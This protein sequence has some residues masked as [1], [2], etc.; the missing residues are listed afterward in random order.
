MR[1][2]VLSDLHIGPNGAWDFMDRHEQLQRAL[3]EQARAHGP[4]LHL[5]LNGDSFDFLTFADPLDPSTAVR[6]AEELVCGVPGKALLAGMRAVLTAGGQVTVRLGNH[7]LELGFPEVQEVLRGRLGHAERLAFD[8][9]EVMSVELGGQRLAI[10]HGEHDDDWN[11]FPR[12]RLGSAD[13]AVYPPG[14]ELVHGALNPAKLLGYR[15]ADLLKP[16]HAAAAAA[17]VVVDPLLMTRLRG[18]RVASL[19]WRLFWRGEGELYRLMGVAGPGT[20]PSLMELDDQD[21]TAWEQA[22]APLQR[23]HTDGAAPSGTRDLPLARRLLRALFLGRS[24]RVRIGKQGQAFF[25]LEP[26]LSEWDLARG[27]EARSG[28]RLVLLGHSHAATF[29]RFDGLTVLNTGTW[30]PLIQPPPEDA[31]D[32]EWDAFLEELL[33]DPTLSGPAQARVLRRL[34]GAVVEAQDGAVAVQLLQWPEQGGPP[35]VL[36]QA[37]LGAPPAASRGLR[38]LIAS[39]AAPPAPSAAWH[40]AHRCDALEAE[41]AR[42]ARLDPTRS[43]DLL[44]PRDHLLLLSDVARSRLDRARER[45]DPQALA[46]AEATWQLYRQADSSRRDRH[47]GRALQWADAVAFD[48][49]HAVFDRA[50]QAGFRPRGRAPVP[51]CVVE[52]GT[53]PA[54]WPRGTTVPSPGMARELALELPFP[55]ILLPPDHLAMPGWLAVVLHEVGHDLDHDLGLRAL[56]WQAWKPLL[57]DN[58]RAGA[59]ERWLPELLA[60]LIGRRLGGPGFADALI[61]LAGGLD[62]AAPWSDRL[63]VH[64]PV[65]LRAWMVGLVDQ[66]INQEAE[67]Y[68]QDWPELQVALWAVRLG[69]ASLETLAPVEEPAGWRG[70][71]GRVQREAAQVAE[72]DR[73]A[74]AITRF[75]ELAAATSGPK[76]LPDAAWRAH[77]HERIHRQAPTHLERPGSLYKVPPLHLMI[78]FDR[79]FFVGNDHGQLLPKLR[80]ARLERGRPWERLDLFFQR[81]GHRE[82]LEAALPEL[83]SAWATWRHPGGELYASVWERGSG[84]DRVMHVHLS[85]RVWGRDIRQSPAMD[86]RSTS[87]DLEGDLEIREVMEGVKGMRTDGV[88]LA[89]VAP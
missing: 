14:S 18:E 34:T 10:A 81:D 12:E 32:A 88:R 66:P 71:P 29:G 22:L 35:Q 5:V 42:W 82:A 1:L 8:L 63:G 65:E 45:R 50:L 38:T 72:G 30:T 24:R 68:V 21:R 46:E 58:P 48:G 80:Q 69:G 78:E 62:P 59:W 60:D 85:A 61:E 37:R 52:A 28:A 70:L 41:L 55:V 83:A 56:V 86:W 31:D 6:R 74:W 73:G 15:F 4:A 26:D 13:R 27:V 11:R 51:L 75:A 43:G 23:A 17:L 19:L 40:L 89:G 54:T 39:A 64:P 7:D 79:I 57:K 49:Y 3:E 47:L 53:S 33:A 36:R 16:D 67:G 77:V 2:L 76:W 25:S 20:P 44:T 84:Q 9:S 87:P